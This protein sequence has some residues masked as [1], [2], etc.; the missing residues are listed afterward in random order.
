MRRKTRRESFRYSLSTAR[1]QPKRRKRKRMK[2]KQRR[3]TLPSRTSALTRQQRISAFI[4]PKIT[5]CWGHTLN[6]YLL[7]LLSLESIKYNTWTESDYCLLWLLTV[8]VSAI[9]ISNDGTDGVH[10]CLNCTNMFIS[11]RTVLQSFPSLQ[12]RFWVGW[13]RK[14]MT[15]LNA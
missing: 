9:V 2:N 3:L 1:R 8:L 12:S 7:N 10:Q 11:W 6:M 4:Y 13:A 14:L 5:V 15:V